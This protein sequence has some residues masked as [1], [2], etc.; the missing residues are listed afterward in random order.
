MKQKIKK[1]LFSKELIYLFYVYIFLKD[2]SFKKIDTIQ[3]DMGWGLAKCSSEIEVPI[4]EIYANLKTKE[5]LILRDISNTPHYEYLNKSKSKKNIDYEEYIQNYFPELNIKNKIK[6]FDTL[7]KKIKKNPKN[8]FIVIKKDLNSFKH[9]QVKIIDG[10]HRASILKK[11]GCESIKCLIA[12]EV[13]P[14]K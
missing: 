3:I 7:E 13:M 12:D 1:Y 2:Y 4:D 5:G 14:N 10:L 6:D 11:I 9:K 8:F